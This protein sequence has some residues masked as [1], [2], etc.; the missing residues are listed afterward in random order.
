MD[1]DHE[2]REAT[3]LAPSLEAYLDETVLPAL[4][5]HG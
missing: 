1:W 5:K 2:T 3:L 4:R